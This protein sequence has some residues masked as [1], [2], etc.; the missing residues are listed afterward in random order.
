MKIVQKKRLHKT[1]E[2]D[3]QN[4]TLTVRTKTLTSNSGYEVPIKDLSPNVSFHQCWPIVG[5]FFG[6][7]FLLG[8]IASLIA[9]FFNQSDDSMVGFGIM[10]IIGPIVGALVLCSAFARSADVIIFHWRHSGAVAFVLRRK[11]PSETHVK[12]YVEILKERIQTCIDEQE[13]RKL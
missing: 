8:G 1:L 7:I 9:A 11:E 12:E 13:E 5:Y 10:G 3:L 4:V 6:S 2:F